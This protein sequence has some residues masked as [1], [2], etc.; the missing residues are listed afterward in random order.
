[1]SE[2][3]Q[4]VETEDTEQRTTELTGITHR[5]GWVLIATQE[6]VPTPSLDELDPDHPEFWAA[7]ARDWANAIDEAETLAPTT[8]ETEP[9]ELS[10]G[11][12]RARAAA[13]K[14]MEACKD[15]NAAI[16]AGIAG[17]EPGETAE[18]SEENP[19]V[20]FAPGAIIDFP[21]FLIRRNG[22]A[23]AS[24]RLCLTVCL[25]ESRSKF[26]VRFSTPEE[27][28]RT[29]DIEAVNSF[30]RDTWTWFNSFGDRVLEL[31]RSNLESV[32]R[33]EYRDV[34][35]KIGIRNRMSL[36]STDSAAEGIG[37][38]ISD[39]ASQ[40]NFYR[41]NSPA[42]VQLEELVRSVPEMGIGAKTR[43]PLGAIARAETSQ[44]KG[45]GRY[46]LV[47][48]RTVRG[49]RGVFVARAHGTDLNFAGIA[50]ADPDPLVHVRRPDARPSIGTPSQGLTAE[51][52]NT[53]AKYF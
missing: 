51:L 40:R 2:E 36:L 3:V 7:A 1:M 49:S 20:R 17:L 4:A 14:V 44:L 16:V 25:N 33:E 38:L 6:G 45:A 47:P 37:T 26:W 35:V 43:H 29:F 28:T 8:H 30:V 11:V 12:V 23:L 32:L 18:F 5:I 48:H 46:F 34:D 42:V 19:A 31:Y 9:D 21:K 52:A 15:Y 39:I 53:V 22:E 13:K 10:L 24:A 41:D 50:D 27:S